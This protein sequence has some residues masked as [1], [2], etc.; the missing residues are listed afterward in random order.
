M[1]PIKSQVAGYGLHYHANNQLIPNATDR[2]LF[3]CLIDVVRKQLTRSLDETTIMMSYSQLGRLAGL[4][5]SRTL[6]AC[7]KRLEALGL[8][9]KYKNGITVACDE[10]VAIVHMYET[11]DPAQKD[12][13]AEDFTRH[14]IEVLKKYADV[15]TLRRREGLIGMTGNSIPLENSET[16]NITQF[17]T[18]ENESCVFLHN[19]GRNITQKIDSDDENCVMFQLI[20]DEQDCEEI[21]SFA[22]AMAKFAYSFNSECQFEEFQEALGCVFLQHPWSD[23]VKQAFFT[24]KVS[25]SFFEELE[26]LRISSQQTCVFLQLFSQK[27]AYFYAT[28]IIYN[29]KNNNNHKNLQKKPQKEDSNENFQDEIKKGFEGFGKVEVLDLSKPYEEV[30]KVEE[31]LD[32]S[33]ENSQQSLKR[34]ERVLRNR[35]PYRNKPFIKVSKVKD[36][37]DYLDDVVKSPIDFFIHLFMWGIYDLYCDHYQPSYRIED[38]EGNDQETLRYEH[39]E[40][41]VNAPLPQDEIYSLA[42]NVYQDLV[43]AV[44]QGKYSYGDNEEEV[45]FSFDSFE[46]FIPYQ[47]FQWTPCKM[48]DKSVPALKVALDKFYDIEAPDV[49]TPSASEKKDK[50]AKNRKLVEVILSADERSLTPM[51]AAIKKFY[52]DF[53]VLGE[54]NIIDEFTDGKGNV[55][56]SG[57]GLPDHLLKPWCY[58]LSSIGYKELTEALNSKYKPISGV[59]KKAY[60]FSADLV[61]VWNERNGYNDSITLKALQD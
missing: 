56:E 25:N 35:N 53:V 46:D 57:G 42:Q 22:Q 48:Q 52:Q 61:E 16:R 9:K 51:E 49:Y 58:D 15:E 43:G 27:T 30:L 20:P 36:C 10:Y 28:V 23:F 50:V 37:I 12:V 4:E 41:M 54:D 1:K 44:E 34:A 13:F 31:D 39:Y 59:H 33:E 47:I 40:E 2:L 5:R 19:Q 3:Q 60:I 21:R 18:T 6:P 8:I 29:N 32:L 11:L 45:A 24:G 14:G 38:E 55:L 26:K 7:I 17:S